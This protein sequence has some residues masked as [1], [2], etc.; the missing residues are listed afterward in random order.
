MPSEILHLQKKSPFFQ[1]NVFFRT[2]EIKSESDRV[3]IYL[4]LYITEC[5]KKLQV[6]SL[7]DSLFILIVLIIDLAYFYLF[8]FLFCR[9]VRAKARPRTRCTPWPLHGSTFQVKIHSIYSSFSFL[10]LIIVLFQ[11]LIFGIFFTFVQIE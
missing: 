11:A 4:T 2:Y 1:A 5:L 8:F 9:S 10:M 7:P 3:L 6:G